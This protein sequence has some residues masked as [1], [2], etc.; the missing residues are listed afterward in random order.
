M[1][2]A[3]VCGSNTMQIF[4]FSVLSQRPPDGGYSDL[5]MVVKYTLTV[6]LSFCK[7]WLKGCI[8][9]C[10]STIGWL[11]WGGGGGGGAKKFFY[12]I[13]TIYRGLYSCI[14]RS[15]RLER[16]TKSSPE[17]ESPCPNIKLLCPNITWGFFWP[18][19]ATRQILGGC[20]V[21]LPPPHRRYTPP[22]MP[23]HSPNIRALTRARN[24]DSS[25]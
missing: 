3:C 12:H 1:S 17:N 18:N 5:Q 6:S 9:T 20:R 22:R 24:T 19:M 7:T 23:V 11:N 4:P 15:K 21:Q 2:F 13:S 16:R 8:M 10:R 25:S 14:T